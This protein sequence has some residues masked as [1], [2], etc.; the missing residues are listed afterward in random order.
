MTINLLV[1][2]IVDQ[3]VKLQNSNKKVPTE[4]MSEL[5]LK[6]STKMN[7][8]KREK[9]A[10]SLVFVVLEICIRD[11]IKYLPNLL[12]TGNNSSILS[13]QSQQQKSSFLHMHIN[14]CKALGE[15]DVELLSCIMNVLN[16]IPFQPDIR[17]E[18]KQRLLYSSE[19]LNLLTYISVKYHYLSVINKY[20]KIGTRKK[21]EFLSFLTLIFIKKFK[22][23]FS[24]NNLQCD[25]CGTYI[26]ITHNSKNKIMLLW[27]N[28]LIKYRV[29][30]V[31]HCEINC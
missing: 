17:L 29:L 25:T 13:G 14:T 7:P 5:E 3:V 21:Y 23:S 1:L 6:E 19:I 11:L 15:N 18:S 30:S 27:Q 31:S 2:R 8:T 10:T 28:K 12:E 22:I 4:K 24:T 16:Q 9:N 26:F 20:P